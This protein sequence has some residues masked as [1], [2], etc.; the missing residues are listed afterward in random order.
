MTAIHVRP[1]SASDREAWLPLWR[2]Y[3]C[4]YETPIDDE[5]TAL[6]WSRLVDS[7]GPIKGF[8]AIDEGRL[9]GISHYLFHPSSWTLADYC[10][11]QDL[12][13]AEEARGRG[14]ARALIE[15]VAFAAE[16]AGAARLYWLTHESNTA[17][18]TLYD[19]IAVRSGF[20]QYRL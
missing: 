6:T 18:R 4:F 2:G 12:F 9:I 8:A 19:R 1:L 13:V 7:R 15:A 5:V 20:I 16:T 3:Q 14:A 17:A 11:L 10:Y